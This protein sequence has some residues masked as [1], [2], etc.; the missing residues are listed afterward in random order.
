MKCPFC[1]KEMKKGV[2][3]SQYDLIWTPKKYIA[4]KLH[5]DAVV[6][7]EMS[8][9]RGACTVSYICECCKKVVI[10]YAEE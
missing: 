7:S 2:I 3:Q 1:N 8:L 10:D 9:L 5:D 6:L 4:P